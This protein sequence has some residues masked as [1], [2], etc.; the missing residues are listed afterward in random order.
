MSR[1]QIPQDINPGLE[2]LL[3]V[4]LGRK[5]VTVLRAV[6]SKVKEGWEDYRAGD[7]LGRVA[8]KTMGY[9][10]ATAAGLGVAYAGVCAFMLL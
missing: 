2:E 4:Q 10:L 6:K 7:S 5:P 9:G 3:Y 1:V 8:L